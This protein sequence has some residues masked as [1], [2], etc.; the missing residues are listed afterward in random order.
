MHLAGRAMAVDVVEG[1][2]SLR[3]GMRGQHI[4]QDSLGCK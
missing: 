1:R 3:G 2:R 4:S